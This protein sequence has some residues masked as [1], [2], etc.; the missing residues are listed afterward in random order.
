MR[1]VVAMVLAVVGAALFTLFVSSGVAT[2]AVDKM[3]FDNPDQVSDMHSLIFM[4]MNF[5]GL[6]LGWAVGWTVAGAFSKPDGQRPS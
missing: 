3:A 6:L 5:L 2:W 1:Y 4:G